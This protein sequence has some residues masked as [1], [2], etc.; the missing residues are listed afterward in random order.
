MMEKLGLHIKQIRGISY[1]PHEIQDIEDDDLVP[2]IKANNITEDGFY[3]DSL[4]FIDK[5]RVKKE[6]FIKSGDIVLAASSGSKKI[7][8][9]NIQFDQD[10]HGSFGA[11]CKLIRPLESLHPKYLYHFFRTPYYRRFIEK[12]VQ[13]ANINNL[14]NEYIDNMLI[15]VLDKEDQIRIATLLSRVEALIATRKN[16]LQQLD[17]FLKSTFLEMF[18]DP[19]KNE[20]GWEKPELSQ[21]G[22][23]S[24]GNTPPRKDPSNYGSKYIEWIKTNNIHEDSMYL[25]KA[26]E[27]LTKDGVKKG[28]VLDSGAVLIACIAGSISSI[29]RSAV[30]NRKVSFNQQINA[31]QPNGD[32]DSIFLYWLF[33]I[34]KKYIEN[35]PPKGMKKII[36]KGNFE[37]IKLIKPPHHVQ[38]KFSEIALKTSPIK[39][40]YKNS[41]FELE[42]L[43]AALSQK[44]F[45]GELDLSRI[46]LPENIET[47]EHTEKDKEATSVSSV[48]EKSFTDPTQGN[49][50]ISQ[51]L[52]DYQAAHSSQPF[53]VEAFWRFAE[54]RAEELAQAIETEDSPRFALAD[55]EQLKTWL[56]AQIEQGDMTQS[57]SMEDKQ[58]SLK[59]K[60]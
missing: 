44:A 35:I 27:Y 1:K 6:Q 58:I 20:K 38:K 17:D 48:V 52:N 26:E 37:K 51:W 21:F 13:G 7:I 2:I 25:T 56:F 39:Q 45:K 36:T 3:D 50:F 14:K 19:V 30:A 28:R 23:I 40:E 15:Q 53:S 60:S 32:V 31:I 16:N 18:G 49:Q 54:Q 57:F 12:S 34:S 41:L 59:V 43:Y 55:Y 33:K 8:G 10:F 9:K 29:G 47:T 42:N 11:F 5:N 4:I 24:T 22:V 46:P